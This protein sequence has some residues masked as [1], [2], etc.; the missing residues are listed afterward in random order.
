MGASGPRG[1]RALP[2]GSREIRRQCG[3]RETTRNDPPCVTSPISLCT[4]VFVSEHALVQCVLQV[5]QALPHR[6]DNFSLKY[7]H[8]EVDERGIFVSSLKASW[9]KRD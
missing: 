6:G 9:I 1:I 4:R 5:A 2:L 7:V 3:S 8:V